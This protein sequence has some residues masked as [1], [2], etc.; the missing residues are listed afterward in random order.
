MQNATPI[1][2]LFV[3]AGVCFLLA[4][5]ARAEARR[6]NESDEPACQSAVFFRFLRW[7]LPGGLAFYVGL[8]TVMAI[9]QRAMIYHPQVATPEQVDQMAQAVGLERWTNAVGQF[10]GLK[11]LASKQPAAGTVLIL[12]GNGGRATAC[13]HYADDLQTAAP[14]DVFILENPGYEDRPGTPSQSSFFNAAAGAFEMLPTNQPIYLVGESLGTGVAAY[15]AGTYPQRVAGVLL[16]SPFDHLT[17]V[18]QSHCPLLPVSLLLLDRFPSADYLRQYH[19]PVGMTVDGQDTVVP[20][21]FGLRLYHGYDGPKRLW[22]FPDGGH[23]Q[24]QEPAAQFWRE[25]VDF[26][27]TN[28]SI[29]RRQ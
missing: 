16:V 27:R 26:W 29:R 5:R 7:W 4:R 3:I 24:I 20:E 23:C 21:R 1:V 2:I 22:E 25:V 10:I 18:A 9:Y 28:S 14:F 17:G 13:A 12:Y 6:Q 15:L 8:C 11:R 19:G